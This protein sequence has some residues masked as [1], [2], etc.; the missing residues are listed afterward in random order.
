MSVRNILMISPSL[1]DGGSERVMAALANGLSSKYNVEMALV[2]EKKDTYQLDKSVNVVRFKAN[3]TN[4]IVRIF[5]RIRFIRKELKKNDCCISF[6][7]DINFMVLIAGIGLKVPIIVSERANP[8]MDDKRSKLVKLGR[9]FL[10]PLATKIVFQTKDAQGYF[11]DKIQKKSYVIPNPV[12]Q[13]PEPYNGVRKKNI[14]GIGRLVPQKNFT[15]LINAF[16][17]VHEKFEDY[18]LTIYG[19]GPKLE[20]LK[21][22]VKELGLENSVTFPGYVADVN[23]QT[24]DAGIYVSASDYEG[25]SNTM[26]EALAMGIPT[27]CTDCPVGGA[28]LMIKNNVNGILI[29]VGDTKALVNAMLKIIENKEFAESIACE[30]KKVREEYSLEKV[31]KQWEQVILAAK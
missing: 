30:A 10:Y 1:T 6:M 9:K 3:T 23:E 17:K 13:M 24:K 7:F 19:E 11:S 2:R 12:R 27:I 21:I 26:I 31:C 20:E 18:T 14:V 5:R 25:I 4:S 22:Q 28:A 8:A 29:P 16:A 15:M